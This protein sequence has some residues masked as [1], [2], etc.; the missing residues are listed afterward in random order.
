MNDTLTIA[1]SIVGALTGLVSAIAAALSARS[2]AAT[3]RA[4]FEENRRREIERVS[5]LSADCQID[6]DRIRTL[7]AECRLA[8]KAAEIF[9]GSTEHSGIAL[10]IAAVE[11]KGTKAQTLADEAKE[12]TGP[13]GKLAPAKMDD[14]IEHRV[15]LAATRSEIQAIREDLNGELQT[16]RE[17]NAE[18]RRLRLENLYRP[19]ASA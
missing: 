4:S 7:V 8:Y 3:N 19:S 18:H 1:I 11:K 17:E 13:T 2:A 16:I 12:L 15:R 14:A 10:A 5:L 6:A 9:S